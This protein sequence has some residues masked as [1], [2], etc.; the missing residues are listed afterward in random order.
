MKRPSSSP[1]QDARRH[2]SNP[3]NSLTPRP[4]TSICPWTH[5]V[6]S[7]PLN[8]RGNK[9]RLEKG[10]ESKGKGQHTVV[11]QRWK[12]GPNQRESINKVQPSIGNYKS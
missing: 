12:P 9:L 2:S 5:V 7:R 8:L 11:I 10:G 1:D 6:D 3:R 4:D